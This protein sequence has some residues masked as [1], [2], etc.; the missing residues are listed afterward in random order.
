MVT[1]IKS[2]RATMDRLSRS[3][4]PQSFLSACTGTDFTQIG[5]I[6]NSLTSVSGVVADW[7]SER[8]RR[9]WLSLDRQAGDVRL[10]VELM[11]RLARI[12]PQHH[13]SP[14]TAEHEFAFHTRERP[15]SIRRPISTASIM[16][17]AGQRQQRHGDRLPKLHIDYAYTGAKRVTAPVAAGPTWRQRL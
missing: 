6:T 4:A 17:Q 15:Q 14:M 9:I 10:H 16:R 12:R 5:S 7:N 2:S 13:R 1:A 3:P 11:T 8:A